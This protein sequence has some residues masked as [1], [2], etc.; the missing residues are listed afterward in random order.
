[1]KDW[2][3]A[4][5]KVHDISGLENPENYMYERKNGIYYPILNK[6]PLSK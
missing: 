4:K 2:N 5:T 1:M 3:Y 6:Y